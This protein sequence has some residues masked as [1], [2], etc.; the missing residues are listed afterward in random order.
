MGEQRCRRG[1]TARRH[2][3]EAGLS[4]FDTANSYSIGTAQELL[5]AAIAGR[6][7][8]LFLATKGSF[9]IGEGPNDHGSSRRF[10]LRACEE[11]LRRLGTDHVEL[12]Y[13][14]TMDANTPVDETLRALDDLVTSGK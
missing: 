7:Q 1:N 10:I 5:G 14:H 3:P 8:H 11:S 6:R 13:M 9:P 4:F 2:L 12:Y